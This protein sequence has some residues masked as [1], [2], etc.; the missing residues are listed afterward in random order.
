MPSAPRC[1]SGCIALVGRAGLRLLG[2]L[3][4]PREAQAPQ[5]HG[6]SLLDLCIRQQPMESRRSLSRPPPRIVAE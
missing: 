5:H 6:I 4:E 1:P 3:R 2:V